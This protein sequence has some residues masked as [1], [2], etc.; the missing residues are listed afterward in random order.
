MALD[1]CRGKGR[2]Q[3][4]RYDVY[5]NVHVCMYMHACIY[6]HACMYVHTYMHI[7]IHDVYM[8]VHVCMY[9]YTYMH[10]YML[11]RG[12]RSFDAAAARAAAG[13]VATIR[14]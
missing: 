9:I 13:K 2:G 3:G 12:V 6:I 14:A 5:K 11:G 7:H 4:G 10:L 8:Y 1:D